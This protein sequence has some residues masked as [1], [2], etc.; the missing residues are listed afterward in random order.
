[1]KLKLKL[2]LFFFL[3]S[4]IIYIINFLVHK[5]IIRSSFSEKDQMELGAAILNEDLDI[6]IKLKSIINQVGSKN[7][8]PLMFAL[9]NK[10]PKSF[11][12]LI[13]NGAN[14]NLIVENES[15]M[16]LASINNDLYYLESCLE[17]GGDL[18]LL[19]NLGKR[20]LFFALEVD[21]YESTK[22]LLKKGAD[23]N[24]SDKYNNTC[25]TK[26][27][28]LDEYD[29]VLF[30]LHQGANPFLSNE[31]IKLKIIYLVET[32]FTARDISNKRYKNL[33]IVIEKL[34][35]LG[36]KFK[37][38]ELDEKLKE[39]ELKGNYKSR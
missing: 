6:I 22:L 25:F 2:L 7:T 35:S 32:S 30:L 34:E 9:K 21:N 14:I 18:N 3:L 20:P 39:E 19:H 8:T 28:A 23:I 11:K 4:L 38:Q 10:K 33:P 12:S 37:L 1:M 24:L 27:L 26:L 29:K 16:K 31:R 17:N 13:E 5:I 15:V 36:F